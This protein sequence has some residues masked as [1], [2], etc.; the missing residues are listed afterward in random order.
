M[1]HSENYI[2]QLREQFPILSKRINAH[3]LTYLD[4]AATTQKPLAVINALQQY[5]SGMNANVHRASHTLSSEA[6]QAFESARDTVARYLN[7][8][9]T[10][11]IIWTRGA[12]ES[13]N[14]VAHSWGHKLKSGDE[15]I[16]S[17]LEHHANIVPW[18]LLA[19]RTGAIIKV[20]PLLNNGDLDLTTFRNLLCDKTKLVAISH[21][22]N[23]LGTIN[24]VKKIIEAS[25]SVGAL[26][27]VDGAQALPHFEV[28]L[29]SLDADFYVF[30]GHKVYAPT[31]IGV[32]YAKEALLE[33]MI[34]WQAGGEMI[35]TVSFNKTTFNDIPFKFEAG[36]PN[37]SG[38]I[39]LA[40]ALTWLSQQDRVQLEHQETTLLELALEGCST[41]KGWQRIGAPSETVSLLSFTLDGVHQQD[42]GLLLDQQG[43]AVRTG[44]HCAMPL[45]ETLNL[46]G[47]T[48]ASFAFYNTTQ[49]VTRFVEALD[50]LRS[51]DDINIFQSASFQSASEQKPYADKSHTEIEQQR[52]AHATSPMLEKL[53]SLKGWNARYR[54]IM[55]QGKQLPNLPEEFKNTTNLVKGCES[56]TWLV[57]KFSQDKTLLLSADSD[58]RIIRGILALVIEIFN[59]K[60]AAQIKETDIDKVFS[61]LSLQQH[62]S[63]S[64]GNGIRAVVDRIYK[65][66]EANI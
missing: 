12:T 17:T 57:H 43:I 9:S 14:L 24:P 60:T 2:A 41:I 15:I 52:A 51:T 48:R 22:S 26:V 38:A 25:H 44:H 31:G 18:Q 32:L 30:S 65:I 46:P 56:N 54:E 28:D 23:A 5:Y 66:A 50:R 19:K 8:A 37:I 7:A 49:E 1:S 42:I 53:I 4:N 35:S 47:T 20:I 36:T 33:E 16:L 10:R 3:P 62:L 55:L 58:A 64:R 61:E 21:A 59:H 34:P 45:M 39:G 63:P 29:K 27:L 11:E 13:I 6:T 40:T